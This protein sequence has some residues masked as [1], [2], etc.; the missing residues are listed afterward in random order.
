MTLTQ[1]P[2]VV[3]FIPAYNEEGSLGNVIQKIKKEYVE[4]QSRG[5]WTEILVVNDGSRDG[6]EH[7]ARKQDVKVVSH[8]VN[9]GLGA[10]TRTGMQRAFEM[11]ADIA[12]KIDADFQHDPSDI[13]K[14]I[15]PILRDE[16]DS[17]FGSR[18]MGGLQYK[19]PQYRAWGNRFFS[20]LTGKLTGLKVTDGQTGLMAF[21]RRY[22]SQFEIISDY[23]ETQ[24]LIM[25][26]W[27]R[28]M[29]IVEVPVVFHK[30]TTGKSFISWKYPF[31][32]LPTIIRLFV[33]MNPLK[34]FVPLGLL[35]ILAGFFVAYSLFSG[36]Q[37]FFGDATI[38]MLIVGG[39]Q[40]ILF[41]LL[42]DLVSHKK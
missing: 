13:E 8:T 3:I 39:I 1:F 37:S 27:G 23:N 38:L 40:V 32:V 10:A 18:F 9:R 14:V 11:G 12:V 36:W 25:D 19:M 29:R 15:Q 4:A 2:H 21:G 17:V 30:R 34:V 33:R 6:T 41:G 5:Y 42:A 31:K 20:W 28:H 24:Q 7:V 16:A 26:S 35:F 22:L